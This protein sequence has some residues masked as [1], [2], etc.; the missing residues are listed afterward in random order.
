[1][2]TFEFKNLFACMDCILF[3]SN[4]DVPEGNPDL[5]NT[6][7]RRWT[8]RPDGDVWE[9]C[10]G[11]HEELED[12]IPRIE[13]DRTDDLGFSHRHCNVCGSRSSGDRYKA[14]AYRLVYTELEQLAR[15]T[16]YG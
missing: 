14:T 8:D 7:T 13:V 6:I 9:L 16:R 3:L 4:G 12:D 11:W 2:A 1:M 15:E 5:A 10:T